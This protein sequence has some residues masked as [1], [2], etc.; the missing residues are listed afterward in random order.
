MR[1]IYACDIHGDDKKYNKLL[2]VCKKEKIN[3]LVLGGDLILKKCDREKEQPIYLKNKLEP[4]FHRLKENN[5][6]CICILGNDDLE[7]LD[8]EYNN[9]CNKYSNV[10]NV[11]N[12]AKIVEDICFIGCGKV[13][14][15]PW[16][17][18]SRIVIEKESPMQKQVCEYVKVDKCTREITAKEW[19]NYRLKCETMEHALEQLPKNNNNFKTIYILHDPPFGIGLDVCFNNF[20]AGSKTITRFIKDSN[21]YMSLHGHIHESYNMSGKW[22][23]K[24]GNTICIQPGQTELND[25][26]LIF[27]YV[28][29]DNNYFERKKYDV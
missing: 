27:V 8:E 13:L 21:A 12:K 18:K 25:K 5:I 1:F 22:M 19:E 15:G 16:N 28:D 17:R 4:F 14:D 7:L 10:Y 11:D 26:E 6:N 20:E 23:A 9:I 2:E 3:N 29:T 24:L